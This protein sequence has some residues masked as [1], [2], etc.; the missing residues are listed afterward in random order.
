MRDHKTFFQAGSWL[1]NNS[2][3]YKE[4]GITIDENW[5]KNFSQTVNTTNVCQPE[6]V[7]SCHKENVDANSDTNENDDWSED[8]AVIPAGVPA[9]LTATDF[10]NDNERQEIY[11]IAPGEGGSRPLSVFRNQYSEELAYPGIFLGQKRPHDTNR[12]LQ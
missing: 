8:E 2:P 12:L 11:N 1:A 9:M 3:L 10:L 4:Q 6:N 7:P 5:D